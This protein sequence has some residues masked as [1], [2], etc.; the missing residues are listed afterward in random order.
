VTATDSVLRID[1]RTGAVAARI[2]L[3][4]TPVEAIAGPDGL[5][6]VTDKERSVVIRVDPATN[7]V[8]DSFPAGPGAFAMAR[9]GESVWVTSFAGSD[10]QCYDLR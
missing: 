8:V 6:W 2:A 7:S 10:L 5:V 1:P 4:G 3:G 9:V